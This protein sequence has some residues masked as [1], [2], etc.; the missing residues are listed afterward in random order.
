ME[1]TSKNEMS[2]TNLVREQGAT[3]ST[4][5]NGEGKN[6]FICGNVKG[7]CSK[8]AAGVLEDNSLS[9]SEA[10]AKIRFAEVSSDGGAKYIPCLMIVSTKSANSTRGAS[11]LASL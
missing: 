8:A 11:I 1:F 9:D 6:F 3:V 2:L 5:T 7:Y 10:F 4:F